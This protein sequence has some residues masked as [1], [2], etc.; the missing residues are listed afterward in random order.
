MV[1]YAIDLLTRESSNF[2]R[3]REML[4]VIVLSNAVRSRQQRHV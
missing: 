3:V 4:I 2:N 1:S